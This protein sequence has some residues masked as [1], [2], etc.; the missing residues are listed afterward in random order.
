MALT[1]GG[2]ARAEPPPLPIRAAP[3][4]PA[5]A[6]ASG[7]ST[8]LP[9]SDAP[10][11]VGGTGDLGDSGVRLGTLGFPYTAVAP[12]PGLSAEGWSLTPS[13]AAQ[14]LATDNVDLTVRD[15]RSEL[16]TTFTPGLLLSLDTARVQGIAN[17]APNLTFYGSDSDQNRIDH[18][19][20]GQ[21]LATLVPDALFLDLRGAAAVQAVSGGYA[22]EGSPAVNR[23]DQVQT[24]S[25]QLSP[26]FVHRFGG[27]GTMQLGYALQHVTQDSNG[28][29]SGALTPTGQRFFSDQDFTAHE[30]YAI[31]RTGEEFGR[32]AL[33]SRISSTEYDGT[34]IL[35]GAYRRIATVETRYV[36]IRPVAALVEVGYEQQ[37]Y[38]GTPPV[39]INEPVW[40]VGARLTLSP[41]SR[42]TAKFGHHDGF[43]SAVLDAVVALGGRTTLYANY[44]ERLTTSAQRAAD[45][46]STTTLDPLGNPIDIATGAPVAQP[47]ANSFMGAQSSLMRIRRGSVS[48]SQIW[49][50]DIFTLSLSR[51]ERRPVSVETGTTA[52]SQTG[53]SGSLTWSHAL[54]EATTAIGYGQYGTFDSPGRGSGNVFTVSASLA[55]ELAPGLSGV[56]TYMMTNRGDDIASGRAVQN[57]VLVGLRQTF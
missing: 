37:R 3:A 55:T 42:I 43:D 31:G 52:F 20:N 49:P 50:R 28:T 57:V 56:L 32:L 25:F 11:R 26:Y 29:G 24:T 47:F 51:E 35:D 13:I 53:N 9:W 15:R 5:T 46:L 18:R 27:I 33:E 48:I 19:F 36:I 40:S 2:N 22:P 6:P 8:G 44:A 45:L 4:L 34:G 10:A 39:D 17:Y 30:V 23:N 14:V 41:E 12:P 54:T 7:D 16:I 1:V 38:N 21:F